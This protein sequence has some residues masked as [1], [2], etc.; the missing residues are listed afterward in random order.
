M[1][2]YTE[3]RD[4]ARAAIKQLLSTGQSVSYAGRS[5]TMAD[6]GELQRIE[7]EYSQKADCENG[8][9]SGRGRVINVTP[10]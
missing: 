10:V 3:A 1:G 7:A 2:F 4:L 9:V 8:L 6:L 5:L